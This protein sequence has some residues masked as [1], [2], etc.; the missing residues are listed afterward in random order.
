M[1]PMSPVGE[2]RQQ[3]QGIPLGNFARRCP[4]AMSPAVPRTL[5]TTEGA[6]AIQ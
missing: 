1:S 3:R 4:R 6:A 2:I 5:E